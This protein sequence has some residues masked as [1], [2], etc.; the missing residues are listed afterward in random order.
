[1]ITKRPF[2]PGTKY[3]PFPLVHLPDREWP[4]KTIT[5]APRWCS[6]DLRDGNQALVNPMAFDQKLDFFKLLVEIGLKEIEIGFPSA[7]ETEFRFARGLIEKDLIPDDVVPQV[8]VQAREPLLKKTFDALDGYKRA[9]YH[10]YN[11][12]SELQRRVVFKQDKKSI[13]AIATDAVQ[14]IKEEAARRNTQTEYIL[15]YSPESFTGTEL[16]FAIEICA[17][18]CK[19]WGSSPTKKVILNLPST[20]ELSTPNIYADQIEWFRKNFPFPD[21]YILSLH[22]HNDRGTGVAA[23]ELALQAGAERVE[24][25]LFGNGERTGNLDLINLALNLY[26]Q[27][28][29]PD[30]NL[31]EI[32]RI[33]EIYTRCT[34]MEIPPRHPYVGE[35]VYTAFSGSHQDAVKKGMDAIKSSGSSLWEVPYLPVDP[36]DLGR[37]YEAIIRINSQSGKGGIAYIMEHQFGIAL[38]KQMHPEF[39]AIIQKISDDEGREIQPDVIYNTFRKEYIEFNSPLSLEHYEI[40]ITE[41]EVTL[42]L[43]LNTKTGIKII[44]GKGIGPINAAHHALVENNIAPP[45]DITSYSQE[46]LGKGSDSNAMTFIEITSEGQS[47]FG[48]GVHTNTT[49]SSLL[50]LISAINRCIRSK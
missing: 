20:V 48:V 27:G 1:M 32:N 45:F 16:D 30:L 18:V 12:T 28:V 31:G 5:K 42:T 21:H 50:A 46:A 41:E 9:I 44:S 40:I 23:T 24:G 25:T 10:V 14:Y 3:R 33:A 17:A 7:S 43:T 2:T 38:P 19:T 6:V 37:T 22:T 47:L 26:T 39:G 11:S 49:R 4:G 35:L 29:N 15:Q 34:G 8:L 36:N 13:I